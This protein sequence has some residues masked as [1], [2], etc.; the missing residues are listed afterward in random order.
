MVE[1]LKWD[2]S[3]WPI[4]EARFPDGPFGKVVM[5]E[6]ARR[7]CGVLDRHEPFAVVVVHQ[8][9]G[10]GMDKEARAVAA[11]MNQ[12]R[13]AEFR[14]Y[15]R[16][17]AVVSTSMVARTALTAISWI[18]PFPYPA[19]AFKRREEAVAWASRRLGN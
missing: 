8:N 3:R 18:A 10:A 12:A 17:L 15:Q 1:Y 9:E 6:Y 19:K 2:E 5:E 16:A 13:E 4:V 14:E 7:A 11:T